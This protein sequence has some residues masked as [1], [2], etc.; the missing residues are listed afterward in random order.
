MEQ[1]RQLLTA[2]IQHSESR[3]GAQVSCESK[4]TGNAYGIICRA[5]VRSVYERNSSV[6]GTFPTKWLN[7]T[8]KI[9]FLK[10]K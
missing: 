8:P 7:R 9:E 1:A 2:N 6:K 5:K 3:E 10:R 4:T